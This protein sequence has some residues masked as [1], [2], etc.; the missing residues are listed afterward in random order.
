[1][2]HP[3]INER[4]IQR[5]LMSGKIF[6]AVMMPN[7]T[8]SGWFECDLIEVTA[9]GYF[10]EYEIKVSRSDFFADKKK[11]RYVYR[12]RQMYRCERTHITKHELIENRDAYC[13]SNFY[14]VTPEDMLKESEIPKWAGWITVKVNQKQYGDFGYYLS[15]KTIKNAPRLHSVKMKSASRSNVKTCCYGR[16]HHYREATDMQFSRAIQER[17]KKTESANA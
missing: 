3:M 2:K 7:Y 8:P 6:R 16:Y 5:L 10:K 4:L 14:Y 15:C 13:P 9:A 1:M 17:L 11:Q 12:T